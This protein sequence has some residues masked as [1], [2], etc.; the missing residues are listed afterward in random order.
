MVLLHPS[1]WANQHPRSSHGKMWYYII[2]MISDNNSSSVWCNRF[3]YNSG[4]SK[5]T[6]IAISDI[7]VSAEDDN[8]MYSHEQ[9]WLMDTISPSTKP[10][11][12]PPYLAL[13]WR[14]VT[15]FWALWFEMMPRRTILIFFLFFFNRGFEFPLLLRLNQVDSWLHSHF[16]R[17]HP[18]EFM[19]APRWVFPASGSTYFKLVRSVT[20]LQCICTYHSILYLSPQYIRLLTPVA[21]LGGTIPKLYTWLSFP[22]PSTSVS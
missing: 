3:P 22:P 6:N 2:C 13:D 16:I 19:G 17:Q 21:G 7:Q 9:G 11:L 20:L 5:S 4:S 14:L 8:T 18:S 1:Q 15:C 12:V 10:L